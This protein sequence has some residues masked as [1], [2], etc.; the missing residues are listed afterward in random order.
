MEKEDLTFSEKKVGYA[1]DVSTKMWVRTKRASLHCDTNFL[2]K[3]FLLACWVKTSI[4]CSGY[5]ICLL[6]YNSVLKQ[7]FAAAKNRS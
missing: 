6:T 7:V 5:F 1:D 4:V 3:K 2:N